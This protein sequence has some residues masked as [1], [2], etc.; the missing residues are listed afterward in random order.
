ML[1]K[2]H[3]LSFKK[4]IPRKVYSTPFLVFRYEKSD[5]GLQCAVVV[6]KKVDKRAV[7]RNKIKRQINASVQ[8]ILA[9]NAKYRIVIYAKNKINDLTKET[10]KEEIL[11]SFKIIHIQ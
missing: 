8:E 6:G 3:R 2:T 5:T 7:A 4:G 9:Q 11:K 1:P 10:L